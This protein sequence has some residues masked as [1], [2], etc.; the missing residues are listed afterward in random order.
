VK[1]ASLERRHPSLDVV[2]LKELRA[3][4]D[5]GKCW[6]ELIVTW[7]PRNAA[8]PD[9]VYADRCRRAVY[10]NYAGGIIGLLAAYL[11]ATAPN[12]D[13]PGDY[14]TS[15]LANVDQEG[16]PWSR[17]WRLRFR[18]ALIERVVL[19]WVNL[20]ARGDSDVFNDRA[21]ELKSGALDAYIVPIT[22]E[23][24]RYWGQDRRGR[25]T[26][27][28]FRQQ[29][30]ER[31]AVEADEV[32][33][34]RWT[35]IDQTVIRRWE[36]R[37]TKEKSEPS[38]ED[39]A[40]ELPQIQHNI[41]R[42]PVVRLQLPNE[43]WAMEMLRDPAVAHLRARND[44]TWSLHKTA[45]A[46]MIIK[47]QWGGDDPVVGPGYYLPLER[48]DSVEWTEPAGNSTAILRED[49][50][51]LREEIYRVVNQMALATDNASSRVAASGESKALDWQASAIVMSAYADLVKGAMR[52]VISV[53]AAAR[54]EAVEQ[55]TVAGLDGWQSLSLA[56]FLEGSA[57]AVDASKMS[58][59]FRRVVAKRQ[60]EQLLRDLDEETLDRIRAEIDDQ[61]EEDRLS[62]ALDTGVEKSGTVE[63]QIAYATGQISRGM[64]LA[65]LTGIYAVPPDT[66]A[67]MLEDGFEAK[68]DP[69]KAPPP[70]PP[71]AAPRR[72]PIPG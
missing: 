42:L 4:A 56:E 63:V 22:A 37:A 60:A 44:L 24:L 8:E 38:G 41:G 67:K 14:W 25:L 21:A 18:D 32:R 72:P 52:E 45:H 13:L 19:A 5:G 43:L 30:I 49:C 51:D 9:D 68:P 3:L 6:R 65:T 50:A 71:G 28:L 39:D 57:L 12:V 11:F 40:V 55:V 16:T 29:H 70:G 66:A 17:W 27:V 23:D 46:L 33:V 7:L 48:D 36:W 61:P 2:G 64:A 1:I 34:L 35:Y 10:H 15:F 59:T 69:A 58:P 26:W 53:V 54:G 31:P 62:G 20:P 47:R